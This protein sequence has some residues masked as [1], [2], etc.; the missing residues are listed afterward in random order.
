MS[1]LVHAMTVVSSG[2]SA[3]DRVA[4]FVRGEDLVAVVADGAGGTSGGAEAA[5]LVV[6]HVRRVV[7]GDA[8]LREPG[9]WRRVLLDASLAAEAVGQSTAVVIGPGQGAS[10]GDSEAW[11]IKSD[12]MIDL[13]EGQPRKPLL[14]GG[15]AEP[16]IFAVNVSVGDVLLLAT[17][18]LFK[19]VNRERICELARRQPLSPEGLVQ[20]AR[21]PSGGL[22]DDVGIVLIA[23][24][25]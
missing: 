1:V 12:R 25:A 2:R 8:N 23:L 6:D 17:D 18:G 14:G 21:L 4:V 9:L 16:A 20:A 7:E 3:Q 24:G 5:A 11:L 19:Y 22:Q 15:F 13:T 10:V